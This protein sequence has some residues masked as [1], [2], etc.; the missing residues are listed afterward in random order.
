MILGIVGNPGSGKTLLSTLAAIDALESG[1]EV[2]ANY[3]IDYTTADGRRVHVI[4]IGKLYQ[5]L[6]ETGIQFELHGAFLILD[7]AYA[8]LDSRVSSSPFSRYISYFLFQSRK[9]GFDIVFTCQLASS[10]DKRLNKLSDYW[11]VA[12]E[13]ADVDDDGMTHQC[14][15]Y[16]L[17]DPNVSSTMEFQIDESLSRAIFPRYQTQKIVRPSELVGQSKDKKDAVKILLEKMADVPEKD[18]KTK[19]RLNMDTQAHGH[20]QG[21]T[22]DLPA[23]KGGEPQAG[24]PLQPQ[25]QEGG[26]QPAQKGHQARQKGRRKG[27]AAPQTG[28]IL[29]G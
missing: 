11:V 23:D 2:F 4:D 6:N 24:S 5:M 20:G 13:G 7:E 25:P 9:L 16:T 22:E 15:N 3:P 1:K 8:G 14:F 29:N 27:K 10:V 19:K 12:E 28:E 17:T 18:L 21:D 26:V